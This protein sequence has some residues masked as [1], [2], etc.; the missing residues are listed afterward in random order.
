MALI[1][2]SPV[3]LYMHYK[4]LTALQ[5]STSPSKCEGSGAANTEQGFPWKP[6]SLCGKL[7][8]QIMVLLVFVIQN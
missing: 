8:T 2:G 1:L 5:T 3:Y 6:L 7:V 4:T